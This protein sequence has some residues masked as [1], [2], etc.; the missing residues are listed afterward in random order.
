MA[1]TGQIWKALAGLHPG[2]ALATEWDVWA[3]VALMAGIFV[4]EYFQ[5]YHALDDRFRRLVPWQK[6]I[7]WF[8][9]V[10]ALVFLSV[11]NLRPYIY[12]QF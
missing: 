6:A 2:A 5:E 1:A 4:V 12:F 8:M 3:I 9:V 7:A 11:N 10:L